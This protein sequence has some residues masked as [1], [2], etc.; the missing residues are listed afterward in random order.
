MGGERSEKRVKVG[1]EWGSGSTG[2]GMD[3]DNEEDREEEVPPLRLL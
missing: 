1:E 3:F 2:E